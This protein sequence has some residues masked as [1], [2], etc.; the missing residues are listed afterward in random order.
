V[1]PTTMP[2]FCTECGVRCL[3][4]AD[5]GNFYCDTCWRAWVQASEKERGEWAALNRAGATGIKVVAPAQDFAASREKAKLEA[6]Q[7][8]K[9]QEQHKYDAKEKEYLKAKERTMLQL[10]VSRELEPRQS[11]EI[12][13]VVFW[14]ICDL[15]YDPRLPEQDRVKVLELGD[16]RASRFSHDGAFIK[17]RFEE[18]YRMD[19]TPIRCQVM[20]DN[21]R[22]THDTFVQCGLA[23]LRPRQMSYPRRYEKDLAARIASDLGVAHGDAVVLKLLNRARG[24]GVIVC[25][26]VDLDS[27][28]QRLL[29]APVRKDLDAWFAR[30]IPHCL[31]KDPPADFLAEHQVHFW[32]NECPVF[33]VEQVCHSMPVPL[34]SESGADVAD[35]VFDGTMRVAYALRRV[36]PDLTKLELHWLGGYWKLPP[37][38]A[39]T[40][41]LNDGLEDLHTS[42]VSSFNTEE[43]RTAPVAK[44]HLLDVYAAL[45][46]ALPEIYEKGNVGLKDLTF[47]YP[48][49]LNF[50]A[51]V[52]T[53]YAATIR[54]TGDLGKSCHVMEQAKRQVKMPVVQQMADSWPE[55]SVLSYIDRALGVNS[56][57]RG[58]WKKASTLFLDAVVRLPTNASAHYLRGVALVEERKWHEAVDDFLKSVVLDPD[59]RSPLM[60]LGECWVN[61][62]E[63][64]KAI[65]VCLLCLFRQ[66]DA[67]IA[68]F[69]MGQALY[70]QLQTSTP[71]SVP[72]DAE[73]MRARGCRALRI[74]RTSLP[75]RWNAAEDV[76]L[77]CFETEPLAS[78]PP[79]PILSWRTYGWR[80]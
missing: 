28:L 20:V 43:K 1:V 44:E 13:P 67:P 69:H 70:Q 32:S 37:V 42:L 58:D 75:D 45:G 71:T 49:D 61:L 11:A 21:K 72:S 73:S 30:R 23:R 10:Q 47:S 38:A 77:R 6:E 22:F 39:K 18:R 76:L 9:L 34:P 62:G 46:P 54:L 78:L 25:P 5:D 17:E 8:Q 2:G 40:E 27:V 63:F 36:S 53:R 79:Q 31:E 26:V 60:A 65:D 48:Q 33:V 50:R 29:I 55:R 52:M 59:F 80:P 74:A 56:A 24:A 7:R 16:G 68:Q 4:K 3:Q 57:L 14:G 64:P 19:P 12:L 51:Y 66:P 15:K 35:Q 41:G